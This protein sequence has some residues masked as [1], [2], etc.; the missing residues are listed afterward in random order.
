MLFRS[1]DRYDLATLRVRDKLQ[2]ILEKLPEED[3]SHAL[4]ALLPHLLGDPRLVLTD[5]L[6]GL[7]VDTAVA[8][9]EEL[10][11]AEGPF[12]PICVHSCVSTSVYN[13]ATVYTSAPKW[14]REATSANLCTLLR[15]HVCPQQRNSPTVYTNAQ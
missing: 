2:L 8:D 7:A 14:R 11:G 4:V 1:H 12:L 10:N 6:E 5:E 9:D 15:P 3:V 13:S